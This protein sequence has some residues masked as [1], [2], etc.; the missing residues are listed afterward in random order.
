MQAEAEATPGVVPVHHRIADAIRARIVAGEL[1]ADDP[2]PSAGELAEQWGCSVGS[3]RAARR[4]HERG[5]DQRWPWPKKKRVRP[6]AKRI[7]M[8]VDFSQQQKDLVLRPEAE[9]A[10]TGAIELTAGISIKQTDFEPKY[11]ELKASPDLAAEFEI[12]EGATL[13]RRTYETTDSDTGIR[14]SW[15]QSFIPVA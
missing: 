2:V 7:R 4:T 3:A 9:R 6:P 11:S 10:A 15:S 14:L 1:K 8:T 12:K 5:Q 13:L